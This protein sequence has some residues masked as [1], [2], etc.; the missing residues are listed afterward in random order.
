MTSDEKAAEAYRRGVEDGV[1]IALALLARVA[2]GMLEDGDLVDAMAGQAGY[3]DGD[4]G[5][6]GGAGE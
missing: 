3:S 1:H 2:R 6:A 4:D 5:D